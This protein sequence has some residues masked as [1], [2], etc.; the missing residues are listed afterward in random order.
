MDTKVLTHLP[1]TPHLGPL[2]TLLTYPRSLP[3]KAYLN[4]PVPRSKQISYV[5]HLIRLSQPEN[6]KMRSSIKAMLLYLYPLLMLS[7]SW[8]YLLGC[9]HH[10]QP[11]QRPHRHQD[12]RPPHCILSPMATMWMVRK[13]LVSPEQ[14]PV[15]RGV[16]NAGL[17]LHA[18]QKF[19]TKMCTKMR[20]VAP[21]SS[22]LVHP[23]PDLPVYEIIQVPSSQAA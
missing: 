18:S 14:V 11:P 7:Q 19:L 9:A 4:V 20:N 5:S 8:S 1:R 21:T 10:P 16:N 22:L 6:R 17:Y 15:G 2:L 23:P 12:Q 13:T 3:L